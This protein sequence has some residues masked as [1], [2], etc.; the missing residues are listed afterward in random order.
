MSQY[1]SLFK[2]SFVSTIFCLFCPKKSLAINFVL[3][4]FHYLINVIDMKPMPSEL[5]WN[6]KSIFY[7][8]KVRLQG[9]YEQLIDCVPS[10]KWLWIRFCCKSRGIVDVLYYN[11]CVS[12]LLSFLHFFASLNKFSYAPK[13]NSFAL[14]KW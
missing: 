4:F 7:S 9:N 3:L 14:D 6:S 11:N 13:V 5:F 2:F 1:V 8:D 12:G 10:V